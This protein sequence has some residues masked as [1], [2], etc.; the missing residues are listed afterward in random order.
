MDLLAQLDAIIAL[1][2]QISGITTNQMTVILESL[3]ENTENEIEAVLE[4]LSENKEELIKQVDGLEM[5]FEANYNHQKASLTNK[6]LVNSLKEKVGQV[7]ELKEKI[8]KNEKSNMMIFQSKM[9]QQKKVVQIPKNPQKIIETY[10]N[11]EYRR[12]PL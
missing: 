11:N 3:E 4:E 9:R 12:N 2:E 8:L 5:E 7:L 6:Q 10:K 1:L